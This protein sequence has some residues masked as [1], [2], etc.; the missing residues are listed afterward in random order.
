[1]IIYSRGMEAGSEDS[2]NLPQLSKIMTVLY[3]VLILKLD[4]IGFPNLK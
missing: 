4:E 3:R 1:M 2:Y